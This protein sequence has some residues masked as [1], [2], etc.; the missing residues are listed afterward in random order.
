MLFEVDME[1]TMETA[2]RRFTLAG[3]FSTEGSRVVLFGPS[4]SGKSLT[5]RV[6]AGLLRP[7]RGRVKV[8]GRVLF[9]SESGRNVP[10]RR[11]RVGFMFQNYALFPHLTVRDNVA[12]GL[13]RLLRRL[14]AASAKRVDEFLD[15]FGLKHQAGHRPAELS[16]GQRQRVALARCLVTNPDLLLLDE[17]F[18]ALD[19]PLRIKMRGEL[20]TVLEAYKVPTVLVTHDQDEAGDFAET[21]I[22]YRQGKVVDTA[23]RNG[24]G[25]LQPLLRQSAKTFGHDTP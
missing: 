2:G 21:V 16:G 4:G 13:K 20:S 17:P 1:K 8:G 9:D 11:R 6:L 24:E 10:S 5:L 19:Q 14:D 7:D 25:S 3:R 18:S 12:F 22:F 15:A 23:E